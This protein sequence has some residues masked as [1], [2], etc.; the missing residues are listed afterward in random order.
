MSASTPVHDP[1]AALRYPD[2]RRLVAGAMLSRVGFEMQGVAVG[3]E[4][5]ERTHSTLALG[6]VGLVQVVPVLLL[7]LP[8]GQV[9]DRYPRKR[10]MI[11]AQL[12]LVVV[13]TCL[14]LNSMFEGPVWVMYA[15]LTLAGSAA[16]F[17]NP[18]RWAILPQIVSMKDFASAVSWR[19]SAWQ[20]SSVAGPA[21]GGAVLALGYRSA[22]SDLFR[23]AAPVYVVDAFFGLLVVSILARIAP[24]P[25]LNRAE[26]ITR[27]S[28]FAGLKFVFQH[29]LILA[30]ITLDLFAV[31]LGGATALLPKFAEDI[32]H[33]DSLGFGFLRAAPSI[34][35]VGMAFWMAHR[36]PLRRSGRSLLLAVA[37]FGAATI[38]FGLSTH[39]V[40]SFVMLMFAGALDH[41]SMVVRGTLV[42]VLT[43]DSMR[44]RVSAVNSVFVGMSN[45]LGAFESG[46]TAAW[47]G[48]EAAVVVGGAGCILVVLT[49]A[50][51]WPRVGRLGPLSEIHEQAREEPQP[52]G[53]EPSKKTSGYPEAIP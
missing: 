42:Q 22:S 38:V 7:S 37:G 30:A 33:V 44:G 47:W 45:E 8:A 25:R 34:G 14:A 18:A 4:L 43:P 28:L 41:I 26:P 20:I 15:C 39:V 9:A 2:F 32:L 17:A 51:R 10:I 40:L 6:L 23:G 16:A 13:S 11:L 29:D 12:T 19:T 3:W 24:G 36:P 46:V 48:P 5:F 49:V 53:P 31:L 52:R 21:V 1:Y 50:W 35:A 27:E